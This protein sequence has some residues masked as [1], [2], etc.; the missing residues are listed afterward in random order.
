MKR[1]KL[2]FIIILFI[3]N[4]PILSAQVSKSEIS[5]ITNERII[6]TIREAQSNIYD[7]NKDGKIN[8]IDYSCLFKITWDKNYPNERFRCELVRN[9]SKSM[10]HLFA[11][12][13]DENSNYI[14]VEPWSNNPEN[15]LMEENWMPGSYDPNYN[16]YGE[17]NLW[18]TDGKIKSK[19]N[20]TSNFSSSQNKLYSSS[21]YTKPIGAYFSIGYIGSFN[22]E[23]S[24]SSS[25][26]DF[27]KFGFELSSETL[28]EQEEFFAI[29]SF[30]YLIDHSEENHIDSCLI[31]FDWGYG[32]LQFLQPYLGAS[33]GIKWND[34]F[35]W[36][37]I[38]FAWKVNTGIRIP[39]NAYSFRAGISY[40]TI[41]GLAGTL[42]VGIYL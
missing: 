2:L 41:L 13:L 10:H 35:S 15:F 19:K 31:G 5:P 22:I 11:R 39:V 14:E 34:S 9:K 7:Y 8:C 17:T 27:N 28:A 3:S 23:G 4:I 42:A 37:N 26:F 6:S 40:G 18:L 38:G 25:F 16:I 32:A 1:A 29:F 12:V 33:L 36:E 20:M 24:T 21:N 30:D